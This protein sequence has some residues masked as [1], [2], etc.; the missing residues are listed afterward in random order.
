MSETG[1]GEGVMER[2][3]ERVC[4]NLRDLR[5]IKNFPQITQI[6]AENILSKR[7]KNLVG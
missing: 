3:S 1:K 4:E 2:G 7:L 5:E 6:I